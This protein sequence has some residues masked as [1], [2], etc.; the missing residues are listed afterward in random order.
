MEN[1]GYSQEALFGYCFTQDRSTPVRNTKVKSWRGQT[2][3]PGRFCPAPPSSFLSPLWLASFVLL[4][5]PWMH[6]P[7]TTSW[8]RR[9]CAR[10]SI[11]S[12]NSD[13]KSASIGAAAAAVAVA[14]VLATSRARTGH[15][16]PS[17]P[18]ILVLLSSS[19]PPPRTEQELGMPYTPISHLDALI[20]HEYGFVR[21]ID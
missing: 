12:C 15:P 16:I 21:G 4:R 20:N 5:T 9:R 10:P 18:S 6:D 2:F 1:P 8:H 17:I 7:A 3:A 19:L 13:S 14:I 11:A